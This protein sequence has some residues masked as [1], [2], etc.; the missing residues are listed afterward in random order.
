MFKVNIPPV[1]WTHFI[2]LIRENGQ[3][4]SNH[5][6]EKESY[7]NLKSLDLCKTKVEILASRLKEQIISKENLKSVSNLEK[8]S[9]QSL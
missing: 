1:K 5:F 9:I 2:D 3:I 7:M 4:E 6:A 8:R